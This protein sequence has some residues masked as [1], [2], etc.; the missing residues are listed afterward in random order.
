[1]QRACRPLHN[2]I[3]A[4]LR[5]KISIGFTPFLPQI[6]AKKRDF[7]NY[8]LCTHSK[9]TT[10]YCVLYTVLYSL[11]GFKSRRLNQ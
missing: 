3:I 9:S 5:T 8:I 6:Q 10:I 7:L 1:M 4:K 2:Y 11:N